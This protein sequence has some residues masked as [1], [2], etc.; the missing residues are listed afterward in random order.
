MGEGKAKNMLIFVNIRNPL[1]CGGPHYRNQCDQN[2]DRNPILYHGRKIVDDTEEGDK[3]PQESEDSTKN[4]E[5]EERFNQV[6]D[7]DA[8]SAGPVDGEQYDSDYTL[9]E[10]TEYSEYDNDERCCHI[11]IE[12]ED[13]L[14]EIRSVHD[15]SDMDS[16][17]ES[18]YCCF[19]EDWTDAETKSETL[20]SVYYG[21]CHAPSNALESLQQHALNNYRMSVWFL[22]ILKR[23]FSDPPVTKKNHEFWSTEKPEYGDPVT[24]YAAALQRHDHATAGCPFVDKF[25]ML[26]SRLVRG[27]MLWN[28][29]NAA[30]IQ[31]CSST[32][33]EQK[34]S[35]TAA[36]ALLLFLAFP[37]GYRR[38]LTLQALTVAPIKHI[39][40]W[41]HDKLEPNDFSDSSVDSPFAAMGLSADSVDDAFDFLQNLAAEIVERRRLGW[42]ITILE[43]LICNSAEAAQQPGRP[44]G[45]IEEYGELLIHPPGPPWASKEINAAQENGLFL[46]DIPL[47][48]LPGSTT[49]RHFTFKPERVLETPVQREH[50]RS[51]SRVSPQYGHGGTR[52][53]YQGGNRGGIGTGRRGGYH[54][55]LRSSMHAPAS[56]SAAATQPPPLYH[57]NA[58][59]A[60]ALFPINSYTPSTM[61]LSPIYWAGPQNPALHAMQHQHQNSRAGLFNHPASP[62]HHSSS[63]MPFTS[64][65]ESS[66]TSSIPSHNPQD[67]IDSPNSINGMTMDYTAFHSVLYFTLTL[68]F[69]YH[70]L[71]FALVQ[72][73]GELRVVKSQPLQLETRCCDFQAETW[74]YWGKGSLSEKFKLLDGEFGMLPLPLCLGAIFVAYRI[75]RL[76]KLLNAHGYVKGY[77]PLLDPHSLPGNAIPANSWHMGFMWPWIQRKKAHFDHTHD[78]TTLIPLLLGNGVFIVASVGVAKQVWVNEVKTH[79]RRPADFTTEG[80]SRVVEE[81]SS[82]YNEMKH[83]FA[84]QKPV[85]NLHSILLQWVWVLPVQSLRAINHSWDTIIMLSNA[86]AASRQAEYRAGKALGDE[87]INDIFTKLVSSTEKTTKYSLDPSEVDKN[88]T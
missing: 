65:P 56:V 20:F 16:D 4:E 17:S 64:T 10:C 38:E 51:N 34:E 5:P 22:N 77:R 85:V 11:I 3:K 73:F 36:N 27:V 80:F 47:P 78:L 39:Q 23:C 21:A 43:S 88:S 6:L 44:Q 37:H 19:V 30:P 26:D 48:P 12:D 79:L 87:Q 63:S 24:A 62:I 40:P 13:D 14:L 67:F 9:E 45:K 59:A 83:E 86:I 35:A 82:V 70:N 32:A 68:N 7:D 61:Q 42:H 1:K 29:L 50:D 84:S 75:L 2:K 76:L 57:P 8:D 15:D 81:S 33:D 66:S 72:W 25:Q 46:E 71:P 49:V 31:G 55:N 58:T 60:T 69:H 74:Y 52:G 28:A 54:D 18:E 41:P 53:G